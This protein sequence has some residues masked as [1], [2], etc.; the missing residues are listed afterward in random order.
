[1]I[2]MAF[3]LLVT[4]ELE[5][6]CRIVVLTGTSLSDLHVMTFPAVVLSVFRVYYEIEV[7][8]RLGSRF[9]LQYFSE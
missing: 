4:F 2:S 9:T 1:M 3:V 5:N 6:S 8:S 7:V